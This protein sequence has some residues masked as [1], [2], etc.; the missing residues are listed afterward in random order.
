MFRL[1]RLSRLSRASRLRAVPRRIFRRSL[2]LLFR[3]LTTRSS[4]LLTTTEADEAAEV[5]VEEDVDEVEVAVAVSR[6]SRVDI[7]FPR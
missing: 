5:E 7:R 2:W 3:F 6:V 1:S 4:H